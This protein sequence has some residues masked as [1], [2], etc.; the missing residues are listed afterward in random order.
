MNEFF[1]GIWPVP[2]RNRLSSGVITMAVSG[3]NRQRNRKRRRKREQ[4]ARKQAQQASKQIR[5]PQKTVL[6]S[7]QISK[8]LAH[9]RQSGHQ[10]G[11]NIIDSL[12][13]RSLSSTSYKIPLVLHRTW[14]SSSVTNRMFDNYHAMH[15][16]NECFHIKFYD[17][18]ACMRYISDHFPSQVYDCY[19][20]LIPGAFRADLFRYCVLY[21]EGGFYIDMSLTPEC[22][23]KS[24]LKADTQLLLVRDSCT[25]V[26]GIYNAFMACERGNE[27]IRNVILRIVNNS[28]REPKLNRLKFLRYTGPMLLGEVLKTY[29]RRRII[30]LGDYSGRGMSIY[31]LNH[32][33]KELTIEKK[34][35]SYQSQ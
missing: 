30:D 21:R 32:K 19:C 31:I 6:K 15:K 10:N 18:D 1:T 34:Q 29:Q 24:F 22:K 7:M 9:V 33:G 8:P 2:A 5:K 20:N 11:Y 13:P 12:L 3:K 23:L 25:D 26:N 28:G 14:M 17:N 16:K 27:V 35:R 4:Q